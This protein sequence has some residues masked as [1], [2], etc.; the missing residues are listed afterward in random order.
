MCIACIMSTSQ[1]PT[2]EI[3]IED[4]HTYLGNI[5]RKQFQKLLFISNALENGWTVKKQEQQYIF[6]KKH[7]NK[8]EVFQENYLEQ[9]ILENNNLDTFLEKPDKF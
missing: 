9:F 7:E 6:T 5:S 4:T 2:K 1:N 8:K 3:P